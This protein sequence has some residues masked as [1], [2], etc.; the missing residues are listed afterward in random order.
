MKNTALTTL[1]LTTLSYSTITINSNVNQGNYQGNPWTSFFVSDFSGLE[2]LTSET[3]AADISGDWGSM[4]MNLTVS[5]TSA[6]SMHSNGG[7]DLTNN[8]ITFSSSVSNLAL[9][10]GYSIVD[11]TSGISTFTMFDN[12]DADDAGVITIDGTSTTWTD[13]SEIPGNDGNWNILTNID[14]D[15]SYRYDTVEMT[16]TSGDYRITRMDSTFAFTSVPEPSSAAL[17]GLGGLS[18]L[19]RRKR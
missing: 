19:A 11:N 3:Y 18:L 6:I 1:L 10:S 13:R 8:N 16:Y 15:N 9:A 2:G 4:T 7:I 14:P 17:L 12:T 5:A